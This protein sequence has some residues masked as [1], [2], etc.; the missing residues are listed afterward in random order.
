M[1]KR[2]YITAI[3]TL[4]A[5]TTIAAAAILFYGVDAL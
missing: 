4:T 3:L 1:P 5:I 2:K